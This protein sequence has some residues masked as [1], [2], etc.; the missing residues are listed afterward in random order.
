[1]KFVEIGFLIA[2]CSS[3]DIIVWFVYLFCFIFFP[4]SIFSMYVNTAMMRT[5]GFESKIEYTSQR[6]SHLE[7]ILFE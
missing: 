2:C 7:I 4:F 3:F 5:F 6:G 1:M